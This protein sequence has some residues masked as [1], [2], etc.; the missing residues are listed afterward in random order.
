MPLTLVLGPANSAKAGEVLGGYADATRRGAILVVPTSADADHYAR[1]LAADGAVLGSVRT[2]A[3]LAREIATRAGFGARRLSALQRERLLRRVV[4]R[5]RFQVLGRAAQASGFLRAAGDL[6][7]ELQ[8]SLV[9]PQRFGPA[10]GAWAAQDERRALYAHDLGSLYLAYRRELDR[11]GVVDAELYAWRALDALRERPG[12]WGADPVFFYGFDDLTAL[13][14]D[15]IETLARIA[16]ARVTVSLTFEPGH[17]A[18]LARAEPVQALAPLADRVLELPALDQ[19]YEPRARA[20]LHHLERR[21]FEAGGERIDPG[22]AVRLLE[23]GGERAEAELV[24]REVLALRAAGVA[25]EQMVVVHRSPARVAPL[26]AHVFGDYGLELAGAHR[27]PFAHTPLGRGVRALARCALLDAEQASAQDLVDYIRAPGTLARIEVADA[28]EARVRREGLRTAAQA[29]A[30]LRW[31]LDEIDSLRAASDPAGELGRHARR[32]FA[33]PH[34]RTAPILGPSGE[35]D[36]HALATLL[37]AL[38][39]LEEIREQLSASE[40]LELLDALEVD[41]APALR[42]GALLLADP[43]SIRARRFR[44]VFVCG[45][46]ENEFPL[47]GVPEPFLSDERRRELAVT[48]GLRLSLSEDALAR[49]RYLFYA[50]VSRATEQLVLSYCSSDE[51]GNLM[52]PSPFLADVAELLVDD[53]PDRRRRRLLADVVWPLDCAPTE[54]ERTRALAASAA[55][56]AFSCNK[57]GARRRSLGE[58]AMRRVRH[59]RILSA[60]ALESYAA[61]PVKWFVEREL[62]PERFEP[63]PDAI[64]RGSYMHSALEQLVRRLGSAVTPATLAHAGEILGEV[65]PELGE[66][67]APGRPEGVRAGA[68]RAIEADLRRYL[69]HEAADGGGWDPRG[70]ELRFGFDDDRESLPAL[71]LGSGTDEIQLRGLIDRVDV[72]PAGRRAIVR[73]YKSGSARPEHQGARWQADGQLQVALY[74]LAVRQLLGLEP[75]AGLYQPLGGGDLRARGIYLRDVPVGVRVF[76]TDARSPEDLER[77]LGD[78]IERAL[79]LAARLR[80]GEL[81]PCPATCSRDGCRYPGICRSQG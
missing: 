26:I 45:L 5:T 44:A 76:A 70:I 79:A 11:L 25:A 16:G 67:I 9:A 14:R 72:D 43:L 20:A 30:C 68:L 63:E 40:L 6:I 10:L 47:P 46:Q 69:T 22:A 23:A 29:R 80:A 60:G 32:L 31:T 38:A 66:A 37:S 53:W 13:E 4:L 15:A 50:C 8:R 3:G 27:L 33:A 54:R 28:V 78:A 18:L 73:D 61:C 56:S 39:E 62:A 21:L 42:P 1:E 19:H 17:A 41:L 49:E 2:F 34:H 36:A 64:A 7:A 59:R 12:R 55:R 65:L 77:Q 35:L 71:V 81:E 57:S 51:E 75:V 24:A 58:V 74:M 48:S 52:L